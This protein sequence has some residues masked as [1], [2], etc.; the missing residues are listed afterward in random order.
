MFTCLHASAIRP[1]PTHFW[2]GGEWASFP[3]ERLQRRPIARA[4][5][6]TGGLSTTVLISTWRG[7][8]AYG[9]FE[10]TCLG[11]LT[12]ATRLQRDPQT[13]FTVV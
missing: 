11:R 12:V 2:V 7:T 1:F 3:L 13:R 8:G 5:T 9:P 10:L 6:D 4:R